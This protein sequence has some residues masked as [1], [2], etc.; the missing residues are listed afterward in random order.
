MNAIAPKWL[1]HFG[2][3][4]S[5][6]DKELGDDA[7]WVPASRAPLIEELAEACHA[8]GHVL[9]T[10]EPGVGKRASCARCDIASTMN[11]EHHALDGPSLGVRGNR[12]RQ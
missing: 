1:A 4:A 5:P 2:L 6:F 3:S 12:R 10:G 8:H 9:L 7:L 11:I